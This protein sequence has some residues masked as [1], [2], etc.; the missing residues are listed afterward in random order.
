M[1]GETLRGRTVPHRDIAPSFSSARN[2]LGDV[3]QFHRRMHFTSEFM[4]KVDGGTMFHSLEARAPFLDQKLWEFAVR[5]S[6]EVHFHGGQMKA[7]LREIVNRRIGPQVAGR[8][9]QGFVIPVETWL[10]TKWSRQ[11]EALKQ[12]NVLTSEGWFE[13]RALTKAIDTALTTQSVP[14]H[15]WNLLVLENWMRPRP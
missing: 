5:L 10:A 14:H 4:P 15:L 2:I 11:L 13:R 9:K 7:V 3:F 1:L 6:P 12:P 8:R